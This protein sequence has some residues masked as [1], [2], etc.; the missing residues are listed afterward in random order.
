VIGVRSRGDS[1]QE[2]EQEHHL[3]HV[4]RDQLVGG[5]WRPE[6][7][8]M[9]YELAARL[10]QTHPADWEQRFEAAYTRAQEG[11]GPFD[12]PPPVAEEH[13]FLGR[14]RRYLAEDG[15]AP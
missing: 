10:Q 7:R 2:A 14:L 13:A 12:V 1:E 3:R 8:G 5:L 9:I 11:V 15:R 4:V 6:I